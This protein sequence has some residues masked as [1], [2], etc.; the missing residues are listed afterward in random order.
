MVHC[1]RLTNIDRNVLCFM[2]NNESEATEHQL[3]RCQWIFA[4]IYLKIF[5]NDGRK[6]INDQELFNRLN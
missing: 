5:Y 3:R 1:N 6:K 4:E 2:E